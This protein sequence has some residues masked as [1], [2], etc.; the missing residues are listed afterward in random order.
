MDTYK[1]FSD[2][3][4][5]P[6][7]LVSYKEPLPA[8]FEDKQDEIVPIRIIAEADPQRLIAHLVELLSSGRTNHGV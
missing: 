3:Y 7:V 6:V 8:G 4:N 5:E 1:G 2:K